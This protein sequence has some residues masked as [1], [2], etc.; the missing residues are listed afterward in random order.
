MKASL[1]LW[2]EDT[3]STLVIETQDLECLLK[4]IREEPKGW[5]VL[6]VKLLEGGDPEPEYV[7]VMGK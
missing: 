7:R 4:E 6:A 2:A 3:K 5:E 1:M